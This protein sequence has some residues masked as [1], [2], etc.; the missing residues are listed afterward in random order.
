MQ[1][2]EKVIN[3]ASTWAFRINFS[4]CERRRTRSW[5]STRRRNGGC[6]RAPAACCGSPSRRR[7]FADVLAMM[8]IW[9]SVG[10]LVF[11]VFGAH[12]HEENWTIAYSFYYS[13]NIGYNLGSAPA[14]ADTPFAKVFTIFYCLCGNAVI[15]GGLGLLNRI[16]SVRAMSRRQEAKPHDKYRMLRLLSVAY[17]AFLLVG[18][19]TAHYAADLKSPLDCILFAAQS[20]RTLLFVHPRASPTAGHQLD[21]VRA[22]RRRP[23]QARLALDGHFADPL[24]ASVGGVDERGDL[25]R[26]H[27]VQADRHD[28]RLAF[29]PR[30]PRSAARGRAPFRRTPATGSPLI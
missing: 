4:G 23:I 28:L 19:A 7:M 29:L 22:P 9:Q 3:A 8:G 27:E 13:T 15:V 26:V 12:P 25:P 17:G 5:V 30:L 2:P 11:H 10:V 14:H 6:S 21:V 20:Q 1:A 24:G 18:V 16:I